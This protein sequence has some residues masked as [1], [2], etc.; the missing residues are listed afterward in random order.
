M[1]LVDFVCTPLFVLRKTFC[2][3]LRLHPISLVEQGSTATFLASVSSSATSFTMTS[4]YLLSLGFVGLNLVSSVLADSN[5]MD[6]SMDGAMDL[7]SGNM[8]T[9]LHFTPGDT[10]WFIGWVPS[11][12]GAM[13]GVCIGLFLLALVE[14]WLAAVRGVMEVHWAVRYV[15][16]RLLSS[17]LL[18]FSSSPA[19]LVVNR[20]VVHLWGGICV[21]RALTSSYLFHRAQIELS[22]RM[23]NKAGL[24]N[25]GVNANEK[26]KASSLLGMGRRGAMP[27]FI[28]AHDISRGILHVGQTALSFLFMLAVMYVRTPIFYFFY[29][30][31]VLV[32]KSRCGVVHSRGSS[33]CNRRSDRGI[34]G[35]G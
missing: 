23:N 10:L 34:D 21:G 28:P 25:P 3:D 24:P 27:P 15:L 16:S 8:L 4:R 20:F 17:Y 18:L 35:N 33:H 9:Y 6:M 2:R 7:A 13:V 1:R 31:R 22:N 32:T 30:S 5:G 14:R 12:K 26:S 29:S 11:S 19:S